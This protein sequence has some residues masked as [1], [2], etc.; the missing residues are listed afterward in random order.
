MKINI[1]YEA[2][3]LININIT[4][5]TTLEKIEWNGTSTIREAIRK[6]KSWMRCFGKK[7][8]VTAVIWSDTT[9]EVL[10]ELSTR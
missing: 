7:D 9:G 1:T 6:A 5:H 3:D 2:T 8:D 4:D 10:V